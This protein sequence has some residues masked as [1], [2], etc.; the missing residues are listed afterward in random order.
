MAR[1]TKLYN[2]ITSVSQEN[3]AI[4]MWVCWI[5]GRSHSMELE[6]GTEYYLDN[7]LD[8]VKGKLTLYLTKHHAM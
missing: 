1:F 7:T 6:E 5:M 4:L 2:L 3:L 8:K